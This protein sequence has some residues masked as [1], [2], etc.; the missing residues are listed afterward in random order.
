MRDEP[1]LMKPYIVTERI[2]ADLGF[3][4][5]SKAKK[6]SKAAAGPA[7]IGAFLVVIPKPDPR[8]IAG[9]AGLKDGDQIVQIG[10]A[11]VENFTFR[12]FFDEFAKQGLNG[13]IPVVVKTKRSGAMR[14]VLLD[15]GSVPAKKVKSKEPSQ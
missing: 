6:G 15:F 3:M 13:L 14:P 9:R 8:T 11:K 7:V 12:Q 4:I 10:D 5:N 1:V 2:F